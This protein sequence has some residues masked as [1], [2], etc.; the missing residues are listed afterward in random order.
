[1]KTLR[2]ETEYVPPTLTDLG[3]FETL[4][5][6]VCILGKQGGGSDGL[7]FHGTNIPISNCSS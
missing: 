3:S 2:P 4:T 1:M 7:A 6:N 5:Q